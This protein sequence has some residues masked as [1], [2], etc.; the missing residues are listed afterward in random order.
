VRLSCWAETDKAVPKQIR[1]KRDFK[2]MQVL[3]YLKDVQ[4]TAIT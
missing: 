4:D 3:V 2:V 1:K